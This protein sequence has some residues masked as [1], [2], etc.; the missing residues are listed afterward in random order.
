MDCNVSEC[1]IGA[2]GFYLMARFLMQSGEAESSDFTSNKALFNIKLL[3][4]SWGF[5]NT[6]SV[7]DQACA[8]SKKNV[9]TQHQTLDSSPQ[10]V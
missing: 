7:T 6:I 8:S 9:C 5:D 4:D 1:A 2:L 10:L 3:T